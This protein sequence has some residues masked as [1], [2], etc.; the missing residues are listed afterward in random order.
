M[1]LK[2][3]WVD[4]KDSTNEFD[5]DYVEAKDI[6]N[7]AH[8]VIKNENTISANIQGIA[9]NT[10]NIAE[11]AEKIEQNTN[12]IDYNSRAISAIS[13][14]VEYEYENINLEDLII[15]YPQGGSADVSGNI[16]TIGGATDENPLEI[17][18]SGY[19]NIELLVTVADDN[20]RVLSIRIDDK[21]IYSKIPELNDVIKYSGNIENGI[22]ISG[23][24]VLL[25]V[26]EF[27]NGI[28]TGK[29]GLMTPN[30][31][32][33]LDT[34]SESVGNIDTALDELHA[35]AQGLISGGASE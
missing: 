28:A 2:D 12:D 22:K 32:A 23:S 14:P 19:A 26:V 7:I 1:A 31:A 8:A 16:I 25:K 15:T 9:T 34:L 20:I 10:K 33:K 6:N 17:N 29:N 4:K 35:Y 18:Y 5:G 11:N 24:F 27:N 30:Q 3:I 21:E 13:V